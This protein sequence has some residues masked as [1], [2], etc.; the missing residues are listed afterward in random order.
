MTRRKGPDQDSAL[1]RYFMTRA[2]RSEQRRQNLERE[3]HRPYS[4]DEVRHLRR[5]WSRILFVLTLAGGGLA[6][7]LLEVGSDG[8]QG[9]VIGVG[10]IVALGYVYNCFGPPV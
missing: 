3:L 7:W 6:A 8:W 1:T 4:L 2:A 10:M 9:P 5:R